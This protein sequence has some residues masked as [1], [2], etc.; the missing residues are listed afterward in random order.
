M[1]MPGT[2]GLQLAQA[3][4]ADPQLAGVPMVMLTS[5]NSQGERSAARKAGIGAYLTKPVRQAQLY[6][7]LR[8]V[9]GP[10]P[11]EPVAPSRAS[12]VSTVPLGS[13]LVAEDNPVNQRVVHAMLTR[14]GYS[15]DI[16]ED[17]RRAVDLVLSRHYDVVLMDCQMPEL[18]GFAATREIRAAGGAAGA[19]PIIALTASALASDEERCRDAGMDDFL[20]KP[21]RREALAATLQRW[22]TGPRL[23]VQLPVQVSRREVPADGIDRAVLDELMG[24][25][26]AFSQVI[27]S[28]L[29]TAPSRLDD[30]DAA[31]RDGDRVGVGRL[32][33]LLAGSSGCVGASVLSST[34]TALEQ[35]MHVG[36]VLDPAAVLRLR[37]QHAK[38]A[39]AL[40][41]LLVPEESGDRARSGR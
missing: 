16:A 9:L 1:Q 28:Y 3:V 6:E 33:H 25:G 27:R 10:D 21:V 20:S 29:D 4:T 18:D 38:A 11:V 14:L 41:V 31:V 5:T 26:D 15:V 40:Q 19:V 17:G 22:M 36:D 35:A 37:V 2:D 24:L 34:C 12:P 7:R 13:V 32:A 8:E 23:R 30:L 39:E